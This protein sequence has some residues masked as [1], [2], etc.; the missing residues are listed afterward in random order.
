MLKIC[1]S[2]SQ[3]VTRKRSGN[4]RGFSFVSWL[5]QDL[6]VIISLSYTFTNFLDNVGVPK[7]RLFIT[8]VLRLCGW[9]GLSSSRTTDF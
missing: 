5:N 6:F 4:A 1:C 7:I 3:D 8:Q 2:L 9:N